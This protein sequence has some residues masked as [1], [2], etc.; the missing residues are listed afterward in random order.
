M[1][2]KGPVSTESGEQR[3]WRVLGFLA[4]LAVAM[5]E[6]GYATDSVVRTTRICAAALGF[7]DVTVIGTGR[8]LT[9]QYVRDDEYPLSRTEVAATLDSFDCDRMK[10]LKNLAHQVASEGCDAATATEGLHQADRGPGP[11][12]WWV[13]GFGGALLALCIAVQVG[14]TALAALGAAVV[15]MPVWALG[16]GLGVAGVPRLY[17]VAVQTIFAGTLGG[18][19]HL[20]GVVTVTDTAVLIAT[21]W[22]LLV[23]MPQLISTATDAVS[24]DT[25]TATA[26]AASALLTVAG[27]VLG[28]ALVVTVSQRISFGPPIDP[29]LLPLPVWLALGFSVLGAIGNA[30][31]NGGGPDLLLPAA[32]AGLLA[33]ATN[34]F[35]IHT[36]HLS[37]DW[38]GSIAAVVLGFAAAA[39]S[40]RLRMPMSALILVGLT[41]ALLP[42]LVLYQ[43]LVVELF[44]TSG[45]GYFVRAFTI[46]V[47]LG[48]GAALGVLLFY[49]NRSSP[50][51]TR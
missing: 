12:P 4:R 49:L 13:T 31:F 19:A 30:V 34:Q 41:G 10:R 3:V 38:T 6:S 7:A 18:L 36:A 51:R 8:T 50:R 33:A 42:G 28:G 26:R 9:V 47:G 16:R 21:V 24:A 32:G 11:W 5:L 48:V 29:H 2:D 39:A 35:L 20:V 25:V 23:P 37:P 44:H 46:C 14:G 43:G 27:I 17:A 15:L 40:E 22:V 1:T 45:I